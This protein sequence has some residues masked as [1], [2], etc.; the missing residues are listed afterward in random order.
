VRFATTS[1]SAAAVT[2]VADDE[3]RAMASGDVEAFAR[4]L[5]PDAI[6]FP[7]NEPPRSGADIAPWIRAFLGA[8]AV[9]FEE[10]RH[11]DVLLADGW[12]LL[13]T[14]F[15]WKVTPRAGGAPIDRRGN[16]VR[17]FHQDE[18]GAWRL[19]REIWTTYPAT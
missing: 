11:D 13:R 18:S 14:G 8:Y 6:F 17:V 7:P 1:S 10:Q 16:T 5:A 3:F 19:A 15:R 4:L 12:A 2:A 9:S